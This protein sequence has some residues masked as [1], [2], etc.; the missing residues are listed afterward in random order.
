[1]ASTK[2]LSKLMHTT[3]RKFTHHTTKL[4][5]LQVSRIS[6]EL[7]IHINQQN[8]YSTLSIDNATSKTK[9]KTSNRLLHT[10]SRRHKIYQSS[11]M[12]LDIPK[13]P[14]TEYLFSK[15]GQFGNKEAVVS[16][17]FIEIIKHPLKNGEIGYYVSNETLRAKRRSFLRNV[18]LIFY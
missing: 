9:I 1:M 5:L 8:C 17:F 14:I 16:L 4:K 7:R 2:E 18:K 6:G 13:M 11:V 12:D 15:F 10:S 3:C